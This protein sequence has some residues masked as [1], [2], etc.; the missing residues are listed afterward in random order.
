VKTKAK[1]RV[2]TKPKAATKPAAPRTAAKPQVAPVPVP[3][4]A[5]ASSGG[6]L[7]RTMM[8]VLAILFLCLAALPWRRVFDTYVA[9]DTVVRVRVA[10]VMV[11]LSVAF[12]Y[13]IATYLDGMT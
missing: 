1:A 4:V 12:A 13:V 3:V 9:P 5:S 8:L 2:A 10:F 6:E 11:G 7:A